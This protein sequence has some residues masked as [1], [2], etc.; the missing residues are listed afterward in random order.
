MIE[1]TSTTIAAIK[2][3]I[4]DGMQ[5]LE[6][7]VGNVRFVGD[8]TLSKQP[9]WGVVFDASC[10]GD[11][12]KCVWFQRNAQLKD[13]VVY[14]I[15]GRLQSTPYGMQVRVHS[16]EEEAGSVSHTEQLLQL[17]ATNGWFERKRPVDFVACKKLGLL[18]KKGSKG[19]EDF[20]TQLRVPCASVLVEIA[21][22]GPKTEPDVIRGL[23]EL[24]AQQAD[25]ILIIRGGGDFLD[26]SNSYD[27]ASVF[28]AIV[29][30]P[31]PV[32]SAI[33]HS[34]D[35]LIINRIC[36]FHTETPTTL[37]CSIRGQWRDAM[38][39]ACQAQERQIRCHLHDAYG[40]VRGRIVARLQ[41]RMQT[42]RAQF[43]EAQRVA[44]ARLCPYPIYEMP[45]THHAAA[46][47]PDGS[48]HAILVRLADGCTHRALLH[49]TSEHVDVADV[50]VVRLARVDGALC[51]DHASVSANQVAYQAWHGCTQRWCDRPLGGD[52]TLIAS[53][54]DVC[55]PTNDDD[56]EM[57]TWLGQI[58]ALEQSVEQV[59]AA[60]VEACALDVLHASTASTGVDAHTLPDAMRRLRQVRYLVRTYCGDS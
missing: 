54:L 8:V 19:Y 56:D 59:D 42:A 36:D 41:Q 33:G 23:A 45:S 51:H 17:C 60:T 14:V 13:H 12:L 24:V 3:T 47:T 49:V 44:I 52:P 58:A 6:H 32:V 11:K 50:D 5:H 53:E 43:D 2:H 35:D 16:V 9:G 4:S 7:Q 40:A 18:S 46:V 30:C 26:M 21:L 22:E 15:C 37:A 48:P 1:Y 10:D 39:K 55:N 29:D 38:H 57:R 34:N 31:V 20:I 28:Q 25:C 27:K